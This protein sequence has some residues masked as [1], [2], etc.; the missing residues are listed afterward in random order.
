MT[1]RLENVKSVDIQHKESFI[2]PCPWIRKRKESYHVTDLGVDG[3]KVFKRNLN[4][5]AVKIWTGF[6]WLRTGTSAGLLL[7]R[8]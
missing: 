8:P 3:E 1:S 7:T 5:Y 2:F 6:T 4:Q